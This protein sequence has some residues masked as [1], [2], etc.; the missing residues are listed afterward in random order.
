MV[1]RM[2]TPCSILRQAMIFALLLS[3]NESK[4]VTSESMITSVKENLDQVSPEITFEGRKIPFETE[5][6]G[7]LEM[8][9]MD[10]GSFNPI[11]MEEVTINFHEHTSFSILQASSA[12]CLSDIGADYTGLMIWGP[13]VA[14][15]QYLLQKHRNNFKGKRVLELGCGAALPSMMAYR[16]G[17]TE[18]VASDFHLQTLE[19]ALY[20]ANLN[21]CKIHVEHIDWENTETIPMFEPDIV[22]AA[23]VIYGIA[24]VPALIETIEKVLP[25]SSILIVATRD[26]REGIP[27][28]RELMKTNFLESQ[29]EQSVDRTYLP[30]MPREFAR[31]P[32]SR[33]RWIGRH[34]IYIYRWRAYPSATS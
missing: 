24:L 13:S 18:V 34:S 20:H 11:G 8:Q 21:R 25:K 10:I 7:I 33:E 12:F 31:D 19:H 4:N 29:A 14:L 27:E 5:N 15:S 26:G 22:L 16:L 30:P 28:F 9:E 3:T 23:D 6:G 1:V 2:P 17:A 32:I